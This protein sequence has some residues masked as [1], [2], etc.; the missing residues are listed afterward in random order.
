MKVCHH[1]IRYAV[2]VGAI[3]VLFS[4]CGLR[5]HPYDNPISKDTQQPDKVLF[6]KAIKDLEHSRYEIARLT[7]QTLI[8]TYD[9]SEY[10][11]KAK[12]AIADSWYREGGAHGLA[13]AEAEYKDFI[14]FYPTMEES[15]EAQ[16][17]VCDI[18]F[19]QMEKADRDTTHVLRAEDECRQ[20][21]IQFPNSKFAP[22]AQ[23]KLR[24]IQEVEAEAEFKVGTF[25][26]NKGSFPAAVNRLQA[27]A[28]HFPLYSHA[29][30]ALWMAAE[31]Y[32]RMGDR[33]ENQQA[34]DYSKIVKDYPLSPRAD[35]A[36]AKLQAMNRPVPEAD[37]AAVAHM[38]YELENQD[39]GGKIGRTIGVFKQR[40]DTRMAA[41]SGTPS[42]D[43]RRP[44]IPVSVPQSA[45]VGVTDV[46]AAVVTDTTAIDKNPDAR[47]NPTGQTTATGTGA[48]ASTDSTAAAQQQLPPPTNHPAVK[49][50]KGKKNQPD[51]APPTTPAAATTPATSTAP[52]DP[53]APA[54]PQK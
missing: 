5:R 42:M 53:A 40:P 21:L 19:Q 7:L 17:K 25:Y 26:H 10:L 38:Q 39:K 11:A 13:Q 4:S 43:P 46:N 18:H 34:A 6:D 8:N 9:S 14:L 31:S 47:A 48:A 54:T 23:Q 2:G 29:D 27:I 35:D 44:T 16:E 50:K 28:E 3:L 30:E 36:K 32:G 41:K 45:A 15:A 12:L 20:L 33:F 37:P 22:V 51:T 24:D 49:K 1:Q 52:A